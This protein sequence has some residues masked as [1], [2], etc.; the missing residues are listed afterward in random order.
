MKNVLTSIGVFL[1]VF[2]GLFCV[3]NLCVV[4]IFPVTWNDVVTCAPWCA[5]YFFMGMI[6]SIMVVDNMNNP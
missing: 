3:I 1:G 4:L 6:M 2:F 5:I